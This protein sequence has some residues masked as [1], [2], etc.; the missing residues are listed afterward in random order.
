MHTPSLTVILTLL[1]A[2]S[3]LVTAIALPFTAARRRRRRRADRPRASA[4][5]RTR[6]GA[7]GPKTRPPRPGA[8]NAVPAGYLYV[9]CARTL[10]NGDPAQTRRWVQQVPIVKTTAKWIYYAS[11][12]WDRSQ[13]VV[14]PGA[15]SREQFETDTRCHHHCPRDITGLVCARHGRGHR[16][17]VHV[18]TPG[19]H[20][21][22]PGGCG[23]DCPADT[24]GVQCAQ[25]GYTWEHCPHGDYRCRRGYPA[26]VIPVPGGRHRPGPASRLAPR[27]AG[28][29][30]SS[31]TAAAAG[32]VLARVI[33]TCACA[34][35]AGGRG[36]GRR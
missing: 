31:S 17:C 26:G 25:H 23:Q 18:L 11:D 3:A 19:P 34:D 33:S 27:A 7:A 5:A 29:L 1:T 12:S 4:G 16:H 30:A 35:R 15:I 20:C 21:S 6:T 28:L 2:L 13:A 24:R 22:A 32:L 36:C 8:D 14:S 10:R 9:P